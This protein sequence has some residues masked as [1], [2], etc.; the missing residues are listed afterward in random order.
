MIAIVMIAMMWRRVVILS[1]GAAAGDAATSA[2]YA[3]AAAVFAAAVVVAVGVA[4][5][6]PL[7]PFASH[8]LHRRRHVLGAGW[9]VA[10]ATTATAAATIVPVIRTRPRPEKWPFSVNNSEKDGSWTNIYACCGRGWVTLGIKFLSDK[11]GEG[12]SF[13]F[14]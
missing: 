13:D 3:S 1:P 9:T 2:T 4:A 5:S 14:L 11:L 12:W 10:V 6:G 8:T 7:V